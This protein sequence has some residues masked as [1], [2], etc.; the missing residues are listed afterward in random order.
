[1]LVQRQIEILL[2]LCKNPDLYFTASYFAK[3]LGVSLRTIQ[4]D[5]KIIK[6]FLAEKK[7]ASLKSIASKGSYL[8]IDDQKEFNS[9]V[10][11][12]NQ[13]Y[14]NVSLNHPTSRIRQILLFLLNQH[15]AVS[16]RTIEDKFYVSYSTLLNDFKKVNEILQEYNLEL[17]KTGNKILIDGSE[18]SKRLCLV[19]KNIYNFYINDNGLNRNTIKNL[20]AETFVE[21]DYYISDI[22]FDDSIQSLDVIVKRIQD[23]FYINP[24]ELTI[25]FDINKEKKISELLFQKLEKRFYIKVTEEEIN[26]FALYLKGQGN[27]NNNVI[28]KE[29]DEFILDA[30]FKIKDS[31]GIDFTNH[32]DLRVA[33]ASHCIPLSIRIRYNMQLKNNNLEYIRNCYPLGYDIATFFSFLLQ[34][35]YGTKITDDE[36]ALISTHFYCSLLQHSNKTGTKKVLVISSMK[37]SMTILLRQVLLNW[38]SNKISTIDIIKPSDMTEDILDSYDIFLTTEKGKYY[39]MGLAMYINNFPNNYDYLNIKLSIDGFRSIEDIIQ[40]FSEDL[41]FNLNFEN[42][43]KALYTLCNKAMEKFNLDSLYNEVISREEIGSTLFS[44]YIAVPHP[45]QAVSSNTFVAVAVSNNPIEWDDDRNK[46]NIILLVCIGKNNPQTFQFWNYLSKIFL[47]K[48]FVEKVVSIPTF[49]NFIK[50]VEES[51]ETGVKDIKEIT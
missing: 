2:E 26:Y 42:K 30:F 46:V 15:R 7:I 49:E 10:N 48:L 33:L 47:D 9:F 51:L 11:S 8:H 50:T 3:K 36:I 27:Y 28:S 32:K 40:L 38:F 14:A 44:K 13:Q 17:F 37:N 43:N 21:F 25:L 24:S 29:M 6:D 39:N 16:L 35:K 12:V 1:M 45:I 4:G 20:L 19:N 23:G 18:T 34:E 22:V 41:F 31:L 5:I